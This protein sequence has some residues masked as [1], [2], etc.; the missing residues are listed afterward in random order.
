MSNFSIE[1]LKANCRFT[2]AVT[3]EQHFLVCPV[4]LPLTRA[5]IDALQEWN[6]LEVQ[7]DGQMKGGST[8]QSEQSETLL[9]PVTEDKPVTTAVSERLKEALEQTSLLRDPGVSEASRLAIVQ[10]VYDL[11][12]DY[13]DAVYTRYATHKELALN[14]IAENIKMLCDFIAESKRYI[15]RI[16]PKASPENKNYL[17]SHS[18]RST[19]L[20][21]VM[22]MQ[23][24]LSE[25]KLVELGVSCLLHEIGMIRLPPQLYLV[26]RKLTPSEKKQLFT[27]PVVGYNILKD[28][29]FPLTIMLGVLEHHEKEDG[30]GY[31]RRVAGGK[32]SILAKIISVAC[33]YE[34]MSSP[35]TYKSEGNTHT[36]MIELLKNT[37]KQYDEAIVRALL[38][39]I[40]L[41]PIG[42][43]VYLSDGKV[44]IVTDVNPEN[45]KHPIVQLLTEKDANGMLKTVYTNETTCKV[46]RSLTPAETASIKKSLG[47]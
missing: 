11:Y 10:S 22:G 42:A 29:D 8:E 26:N 40:S 20:A 15:L 3:I 46:S 43:Y 27:H 47:L 5:V 33:S 45:I 2:E 17:V 35:R 23:L 28:Y 13:V 34:A 32:I 7:S 37:G 31:P 30:S 16:Q 21:I 44:G 1:S 41:Y 25:P 18:M 38:F 24:T 6:F 14:D 19:V 39:S 36:A 9:E 4:G 12:S